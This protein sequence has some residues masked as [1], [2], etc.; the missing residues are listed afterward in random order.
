MKIAIDGP[1]AA[2]KGSVA[3][4]V[5][6][7][8]GFLYVDTGAM[9]RAISVY[10]RE[11]H[12]TEDR[13]AEVC[14]L[15]AS[16]IPQVEIREPLPTEQDGRLC[17]VL[18]NN[19][20]ISWDIRTNESSRGASLVSRYLCVRNLLLILQRR[21]AEERS[22]VME[23]RDIGTAVFPDADLKIFLTAD[24]NIRAQRRHLELSKRG[25]QVDLKKILQEIHDRD[26]QDME[27]PLRPLAKAH[28]AIEV[29]TSGMT[30]DEVVHHIVKL[31]MKKSATIA[32]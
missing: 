14:S 4:L 26:K 24:E 21:L 22:V 2:G 29:D 13:E 30:V 27:R 19:R 12:K 25:I 7:K 8:L 20:D 1:V 16:K 9:F 23:G 3:K 31:A 17:T 10:C 5:A 15:V 28:D 6:G 18:L 32:S 11:H